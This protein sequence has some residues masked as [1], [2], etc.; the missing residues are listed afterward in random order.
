VNRY[1]PPAV[2][3]KDELVAAGM[4]DSAAEEQQ[5]LV[6]AIGNE[7]AEHAGPGDGTEWQQA[8]VLTAELGQHSNQAPPSFKNELVARTRRGALD[9]YEALVTRVV[10]HPV[11]TTVG[12]TAVITAALELLAGY[13]PDL[14]AMVRF[15]LAVL[16]RS[17]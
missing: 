1:Q 15:A 10:E 13:R 16:K 12:L 14:A 4:P 7:V 8:L 2:G 3:L 17:Y 9:G 11:R 5:A 6:E